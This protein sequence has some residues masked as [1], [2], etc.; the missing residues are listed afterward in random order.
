MRTLAVQLLC[1]VEPDVVDVLVRPDL[2]REAS[3]VATP[4]LLRIGPG[5]ARRIVGD[6]SDPQQLAM[7]LGAS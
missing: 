2:A 1:D 3:V 7:A 4:L 5:P 6:F